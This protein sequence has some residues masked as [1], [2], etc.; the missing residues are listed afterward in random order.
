MKSSVNQKCCFLV[1]TLAKKTCNM[2][3]T[4]P[5]HLSMAQPGKLKFIQWL[6]KIQ[7]FIAK[8]TVFL[9]ISTKLNCLSFLAGLLSGPCSFL[10]P[11]V[12]TWI[13]TVYTEDLKPTVF[14]NTYIYN[15]WISIYRCII[16]IW[17]YHCHSSGV[18]FCSSTGS[19]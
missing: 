19:Q 5:Y 13:C 8:L 18:F 6:N 11:D 9:H 16:C 10:L 12:Q 14:H 2:K 3:Q 1:F 7:Y 4:Q 15:I 17:M